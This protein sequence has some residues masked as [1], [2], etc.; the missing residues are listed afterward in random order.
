MTE[1]L[2]VEDKINLISAFQYVGLNA[3]FNLDLITDN[4][5]KPKAR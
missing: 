3:V 5:P 4:P 2:R 1:V